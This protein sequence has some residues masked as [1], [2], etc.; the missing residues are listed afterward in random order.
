MRLKFYVQANGENNKLYILLKDGVNEG[1]IEA[2]KQESGVYE[3]VSFNEQ[4]TYG[5]PTLIAA[6]EELFLMGRLKDAVFGK[7]NNGWQEFIPEIGTVKQ[8]EPK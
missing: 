8:V 1:I 4:E 5:Q 2:D 7:I 6:L 3:I